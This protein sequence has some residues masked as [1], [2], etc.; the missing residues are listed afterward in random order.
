MLGSAWMTTSGFKRMSGTFGRSS[1]RRGGSDIS[2]VLKGKL[3]RFEAD[4]VGVVDVSERTSY[5]Y[6]TPKDIAGYRGETVR[7]LRSLKFGGWA[8]GKIVEIS[9]HENTS[10]QLVVEAVELKR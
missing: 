2:V 4:G 9:G 6:F 3:V 10:G 7:E 5:V 1:I 8:P